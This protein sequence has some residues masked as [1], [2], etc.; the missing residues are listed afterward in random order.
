MLTAWNLYT[1]WSVEGQ[2]WPLY[3]NSSKCQTLL[4]CWQL[5]IWIQT[6]VLKVKADLYMSNLL[7]VK[8]VKL[9]ENILSPRNGYPC[10]TSRMVTVKE[11]LL[12]W[13]SGYNWGRGRD[14]IRIY[15][16]HLHFTNF[17]QLSKKKKFLW[18]GNVD[19]RFKMAD[20]RFRQISPMMRW[21]IVFQVLLTRIFQG[22]P[23]NC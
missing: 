4:R 20:F 21:K 18:N 3:V 7:S 9:L 1:D 14:S 11:M 12:F 13:M 17:L 2:S 19:S 5:E 16:L 6:E 8:S 15:R 23:P 10:S 22:R